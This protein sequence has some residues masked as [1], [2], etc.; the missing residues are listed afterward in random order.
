MTSLVAAYQDNNVHEAEKIIRENRATI[1]GDPFIQSHLAD[2]LRSLRTQWILDIIR[3]YTRVALAFLATSLAVS[4]DEV[5]DIV[6][7]LILDRKLS[8]RID[9]VKGELELDQQ[10]VATLLSPKMVAVAGADAHVRAC[11]ASASTS[12][13]TP[14]SAAGPTSL[15]VCSATSSPRRARSAAR[16]L[17]ALRAV[18]AGRARS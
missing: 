18:A 6:I 17:A 12:V 2:V 9:Q 8:G 4:V 3:P 7:A 11:T 16:P 13:A 1:M 15:A 14:P 5:E 10:C